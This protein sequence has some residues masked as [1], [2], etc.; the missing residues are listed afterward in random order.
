MFA[1]EMIVRARARAERVTGVCLP[2]ETEI[3][4]GE[5]LTV[6]LKDGRAYIAAQDEN[7]LT[8]GFF[9]LSRCVKE[10]KEELSVLQERHFPPRII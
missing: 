1:Y 4:R 6:T 7:A 8:R 5:G 3:A 10:K 2:Y 9:L